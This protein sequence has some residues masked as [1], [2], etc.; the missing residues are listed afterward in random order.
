[1]PLVI[2][3]ELILFVF[4]E[5]VPAY[6]QPDSNWCNALRRATQRNPREF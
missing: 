1:M 6:Y 2:R 3:N 5:I 4:V